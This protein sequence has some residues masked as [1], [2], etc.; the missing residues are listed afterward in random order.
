MTNACRWLTKTLARS[1]AAFR[2]CVPDVS[3]WHL[4]D[5]H[6]VAIVCPLL[7]QS[8]HW[9]G[10]AGEPFVRLWPKVDIDCALRQ[11]VWC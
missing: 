7:D 8:G 10:S 6:C 3:N 1:K 9:R 11:R 4:A 5:N 2:N